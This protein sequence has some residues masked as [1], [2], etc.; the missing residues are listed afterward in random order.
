MNANKIINW[1]FEDEEDG[2]EEESE[3]RERSLYSLTQEWQN[4]S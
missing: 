2:E 1:G 4:I 3:K